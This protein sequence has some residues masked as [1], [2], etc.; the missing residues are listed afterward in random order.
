M[1]NGEQEWHGKLSRGSAYFKRRN[2]SG[3]SSRAHDGK[4]GWAQSL[5]A[6]LWRPSLMSRQTASR[7]NQRALCRVCS[8]QSGDRGRRM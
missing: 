1:S 8:G 2:T 5:G 7:A 4:G 6:Q 3:N